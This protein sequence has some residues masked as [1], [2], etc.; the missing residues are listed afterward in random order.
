MSDNSSFDP[1]FASPSDYAYLYRNLGLQ[2]VP[3]KTPKEDHKQWKRPALSK[4]RELEN[5]LASDETFDGWYGDRGMNKN[6]YNM[7]LITGACSGGIFV[8]DLD[9]H[10]NPRACIWW[11]EMFHNQQKAGE[12]ETVEQLTGGGGTQLFFRA[13]TDWIPPTCKTS[14]CVDIRGQGGFAMLPPSMHESGNAYAWKEGHEPWS[15][16]IADAPH[17]FCDEID[18]LAQEYGGHFSSSGSK[19][20]TSSSGQTTDGFGRIIDGRE[21]YMTKMIWAAVV[22]SY[23]QCP[24]KLPDAE[25]L[26]LMYMTFRIY[27]RIVKSRI[28]DTHR[29]NEELLEEEGRGITLFRQKWKYAMDQWDNKVREDANAQKNDRESNS[30]KDTASKTEEGIYFKGIPA[31]EVEP[32]LS[33][34]WLIKGILPQKGLAIVYGAPGSGK[35]FFVCDMVAHISAPDIRFWRGRK[36]AQGG[37]AYCFLEGG[38]GAINRVAALRSHHGDLGRFYSYP[39]SM[40]LS[41]R[42]NMSQQQFEQSIEADS[43]KLVVSIRGQMGTVS[44]VV[45]DTLSRAMS[46]KDENSS[47]DMTAFIS[48]MDYIAKELDCLVIVVHHAGKDQSRGARGHSSLLAAIDTEMQI[49]RPN[50]DQPGRKAKVTKMKEGG[51]GGEFGFELE[52]YYLGRDEDGD[53]VTTCLVMPTEADSAQ[54]N[55]KARHLGPNET[56]ILNAYETFQCDLPEKYTPIGTGFPDKPMKCVD[57]QQFI[58][59]VFGQ[60]VGSG[61]GARRKVNDA[62]KT[63]V[64]KYIIAINGGL[65]WRV[66]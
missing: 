52:Q 22:D 66:R 29:T 25:S 7:G 11:D 23:R 3:A 13:P 48:A 2:V 37:V 44:V 47:V 53:E 40:N 12:L 15:M 17:W 49:T 20:R 16:E 33:N 62:I 26:E 50:P 34:R 14:I 57:L 5:T 60:M 10:K 32:V 54:G 36:T 38:F 19:Q 28:I 24:I 56:V 65:L 18:Q 31:N 27:E 39:Y 55:A 42:P 30:D 58:N 8:V 21:G 4:W 1:E 41:S 63:L 51:D 46:G 59:F 61:K 6:R 9:I 45:V 43:F 64:K 35:S